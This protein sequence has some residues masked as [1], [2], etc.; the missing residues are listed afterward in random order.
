MLDQ[1][2]RNGSDHWELGIIGALE[3]AEGFEDAD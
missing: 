2:W 3:S 1:L